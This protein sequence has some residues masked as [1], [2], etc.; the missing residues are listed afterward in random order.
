MIAFILFLVLLWVIL[1]IVGF[2]VKGLFWLFV[3]ACALFL[4]T[5]IA[6]SFR[7]GRRGRVSR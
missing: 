4:L 2:V 5:L 1:G 6:A 7:G 3:I